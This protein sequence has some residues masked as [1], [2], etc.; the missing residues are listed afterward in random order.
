L[1]T[2]LSAYAGA[3]S[4]DAES[5]FLNLDRECLISGIKKYAKRY[6]HQIIRIHRLFRMLPYFSRLEYIFHESIYAGMRS[7][8]FLQLTDI[9]RKIYN[10]MI[11][12]LT[13]KF[14]NE[15]SL[16]RLQ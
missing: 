8:G 4:S 16:L 9:L 13:M 11:E 7:M 2:Y 12:D 14:Y 15:T 10:Y 1:T 5:L 6:G 3:E